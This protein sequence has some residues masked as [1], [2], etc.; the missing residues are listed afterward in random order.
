MILL[1]PGKL[2]LIS[3][4]R[5]ALVHTGTVLRPSGHERGDFVTIVDAGDIV[6]ESAKHVPMPNRH[7][8]SNYRISIEF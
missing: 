1:E 2:G 8:R 7:S 5:P 3:A 6:A 4:Q